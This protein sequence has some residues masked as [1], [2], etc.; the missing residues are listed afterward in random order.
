MELKGAGGEP[1][2][3]A[4]TVLS[5]GVADLPPNVI[6]PDGSSLE[7]VVMAKGRAWPVQVAAA[8][9]ERARVRVPDVAAPPPRQAR[10]Q[11]VGV[12]RHMLRLDEDLSA[13]YA[14]AAADPVLA[15]TV[16]GAGRMLRSPTVFEDL[17]KTI[18]TT[19]CWG[20]RNALLCGRPGVGAAG[21][22]T[23]A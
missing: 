14:T 10:A 13:F 22:P 3:F 11:L 7:T 19:S 5:H 18:C 6:A 16:S 12:V 8:G 15:W 21:S 17:V 9:L 4:R 20:P 23:R 1:V 2:D